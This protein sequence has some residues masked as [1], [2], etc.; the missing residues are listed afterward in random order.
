M[1]ARDLVKQILAFSRKGGAER[2]AIS[3]KPI[4]KEALN[5]L[6]ASIPAS[7]EIREDIDPDCGAILAD[8]TNIHQIVV[9]L[10]TNAFHAMETTGGVLTVVLKNVTLDTEELTGEADLLPGRYVL[11]SVRDTGPGMRP[12]ILSRIFEP[13][14]TTK[15]VGKGS[16]MGLAVVHGIVK[17]Y[18]GMVQVESTV[19]R[20][21]V[22]RIYLPEA[23]K[24][25]AAGESGKD[26]MAPSGQERILYVDDE[27]SIAEMGK[28][29]LAGLGYQV[30]AFTKPV[31]AL[32][33]FRRQPADFDLLITDQT[34]PKMSGVQLIREVLKIRPAMPIILCTGYS[35]TIGEESAQEQGI[36]HFLMKPLTMRVLAE[37]VRNALEDKK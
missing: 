30:T 19:G 2:S 12:E 25:G 15:G 11:F 31:E 35:T 4:V 24:A 5:F 18:G 8:P 23:D 36:S 34:M 13:Y 14:F 32:E 17:S 27:A 6:R 33:E 16:G 22:F 3:P 9:N 7:I 29:M 20:G 37:T 26:T 10:C 21:T 1:R 28:A